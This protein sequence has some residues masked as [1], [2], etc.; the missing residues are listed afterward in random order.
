MGIRSPLCCQTY[1]VRLEGGG[2]GKIPQKGYD[3]CCC[4]NIGC[5]YRGLQNNNPYFNALYSTVSIIIDT[6]P[7]KIAFFITIL[8]WALFYCRR[9]IWA[10]RIKARINFLHLPFACCCS[11]KT[12]YVNWREGPLG[13]WRESSLVVVVVS[14][15][16]PMYLTRV[17][18]CNTTRTSSELWL[19]CMHVLSNTHTRLKV[20]DDGNNQQPQTK[21]QSILQ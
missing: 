13:F 1:Y 19:L 10:I 9:Y 7:K 20:R 5:T 8:C 3:A 14:S 21:T 6:W 15:E 2:G 12:N 17:L 18:F 11:D 16:F 4:Y